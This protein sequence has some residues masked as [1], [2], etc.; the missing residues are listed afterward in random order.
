MNY[1]IADMHI[2]HEN[3][4]AYDNRPFATIYEHD[5]ELKQR[6]NERVT[7]DDDVYIIGNLSWLSVKNTVKFLSELNGR[8]HLIKGSHDHVLLREKEV[9][10]C[11]VEVRDYKELA[12]GNGTG[13]ILCH[14]PM[15][16]FNNMQKGWF[17]FYAGLHNS[18][19]D[20]VV[21]RVK[22]QVSDMQHFP[23]KMLNIGAM[24]PWMDFTPRTFEELKRECF[25]NKKRRRKTA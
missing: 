10:N 23:A 18:Y 22:E 25:R 17:H 13:I 12:L 5:L 9:W 24:K 15:L 11:F 7:D 6:W 21:N 20:N 14:Y 1:F 8:K 4:L 16:F 3:I 19:Q 2:G